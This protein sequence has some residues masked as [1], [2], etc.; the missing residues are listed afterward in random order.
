MMKKSFVATKCGAHVVCI[1]SMPVSVHVE[2]T[3]WLRN[4]RDI[5]FAHSQMVLQIPRAPSHNSKG[6]YRPAL[7]VSANAEDMWLQG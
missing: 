5:A 3:I 4:E 6:V 2:R 1:R 7:F